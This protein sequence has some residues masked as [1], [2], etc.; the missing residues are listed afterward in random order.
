MDQSISTRQTITGGAHCWAARTPRGL[1]VI[2]G[3]Q[4]APGRPRP[5]IGVVFGAGGVLGAA[6]MTGALPA[7][8]ERLP[9]ALNDA[10]VIVGTSAGS[11]VAAA[12]RCRVSIGEML[13]YQR[14]EAVGVLRDSGVSDL[15]GGA[16]PPPPQLRMG[17]PRLML[18]SLLTPH[19]VHPWVGASAWLPRGRASHAALRGMVHTLHCHAY[20]Q[21]APHGPPPDWVGGGQT[22]VV[23]VD[24][25]SG[26]RVIFGREGAP[27][28][29]LPDAVV[30][31]CSIPGWYEPAVIQGRRYVDGGVRSPNSLGVLARAGVD[32]VYV[33]APMAS[34]VMDRPRKPHEHLERRLRG[35]LTLALLR[36]ARTLRS[37]GLRVTLLTPGPED[38]AAMGVNLMDPRRRRAVLETS[39]RTSAAALASHRRF[40]PAAA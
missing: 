23:A 27:S 40:F 13:A 30:A 9:C 34:L 37:L 21:T 14:G 26:R 8:Q 10:D 32:E 24:Y 19:R 29:R 22:W 25:D 4:R 36:E 33:L 1:E 20:R 16:W 5:R 39:L 11:V 31:S 6:W 38:V 17:S 2:V 3:P 35:L 7:L 15:D 12:L 18:A 28:A